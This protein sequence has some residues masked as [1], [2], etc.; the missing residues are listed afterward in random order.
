MDPSSTGL[1]PAWR[2]AVVHAVFGITWPDG[3]SAG[4]IQQLRM[5]LESRLTRVRALAPNSGAYL[6]EVRRIN[7]P[8]VLTGLNLLYGSQASMF[9]PDA[10]HAFFGGHYDKLREVKRK[11]DPHDVFVVLEGVGADEWD[12]NLRCR[13]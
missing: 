3:A 13:V 6:N 10:R 8:D 7:G 12:E 1:N 4:V 2:K 5:S 11:Y 9:E